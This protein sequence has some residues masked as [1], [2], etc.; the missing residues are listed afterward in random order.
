MKK[1]IILTAVMAMVAIPASAQ[2]VAIKNNLAA[3]ATLSPNIAVE[4]GFAKRFSVDLYGSWNPFIINETTSTQFRH[5]LIQPEFRLWTCE[6][7]NGLFFGAHGFY[8][9]YN[10]NNINFYPIRPEMKD[11]RWQGDIYGAGFT[12]GYQWILGKRW[13]FEAAVG[14]GLIVSEWE[15]WDCTNCSDPLDTGKISGI[16]PTRVSLAVVFFFN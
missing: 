6:S 8:G 13:N 7:F 16:M 11:F 1:L 5:L 12:V 15:K 2:K 3:T 4:V 10:I 9:Q 14:G